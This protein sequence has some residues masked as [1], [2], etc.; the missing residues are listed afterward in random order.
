[1]QK[2]LWL[3]RQNKTCRHIPQGHTD[4]EIPKLY[5]SGGIRTHASERL[6]PKTSALDRSATLP[7]HLHGFC[8]QIQPDPPLR[9]PLDW[10]DVDAGSAGSAPLAVPMTREKLEKWEICEIHGKRCTYAVG[11]TKQKKK[12]VQDV[13]S[14]LACSSFYMCMTDAQIFLYPQPVQHTSPNAQ[15]KDQYTTHSTSS[16]LQLTASTT[17]AAPDMSQLRTFSYTHHA[18]VPTGP[19]CLLRGCA[20]A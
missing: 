17:T 4:G 19:M 14:S 20:V 15:P 18:L 6:V 12:R 1:M 10:I 7:M 5:G 9:V 8:A 11:R 13:N 3:Y 16:C 2:S